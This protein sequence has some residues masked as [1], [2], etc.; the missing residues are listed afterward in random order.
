MGMWSANVTFPSAY[1]A[2][3]SRRDGHLRQFVMCAIFLA[4]P[5]FPKHVNSA[6]FRIQYLIIKVGG[7]VAYCI[8]VSVWSCHKHLCFLFNTMLCLLR[9][10]GAM[11]SGSL[12]CSAPWWWRSA[13]ICILWATTS[14]MEAAR[15][16]GRLRVT[17]P[18]ARQSSIE[19]FAKHTALAFATHIGEAL[20][21]FVPGPDQS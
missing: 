20:W 15:R 9:T 12:H 1:W 4:S 14:L 3:I 7:F 2:S 17:E 19:M 5:G 11:A 16:S 10:C 21:V 8:F 13:S 18:H 6:F